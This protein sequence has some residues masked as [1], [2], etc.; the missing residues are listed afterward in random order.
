[1]AAMSPD[2]QGLRAVVT[3]AGSGIGLE[4][5]SLLAAQGAT[6]CGLDLNEG[7]FTGVGTYVSCDVSQE[8]S[9]TAAAAEV[10]A[11]FGGGLDIL[12]NNAGIGAIG[13]VVDA[14]PEDW[15]KVF[16]V[17]VFGTARVVRHL[18]P[19]L[20]KG[21]NPVIVNTC[22][23]AAPIG[24]PK[25]AV[26]SASKGALESLTRAMAADFLDD[27][28]RVNGVNPGTADTPWVQ[29]L[30]AQTDDPAGE[31]AR[32]EARQPI[33]RLVSAPEVA[34][35][36]SYLAHPKSLSTTGTILAVDGGMASLRLPR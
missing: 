15:E 7:G 33:G 20:V 3:G 5:A 14:S 16:S 11:V 32:L 34:H 4:V 19:L 22:S 8:A 29:R 26:Y 13:S 30:L 25:R 24:L 28:I 35:A 9:V 18:H 23:V 1:M 36:I 6:V 31:R 2:F 21:T 10:A 27:N 12:I 17:N